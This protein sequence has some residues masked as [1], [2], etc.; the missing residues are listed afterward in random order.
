MFFT[1]NHPK[2]DVRTLDITS[3]IALDG[4]IHDFAKSYDKAAQKKFGR[5]IFN[6][7]VDMDPRES[8][9]RFMES[10]LANWICDALAEDYSVQEGD[11]TVDI[12]IL[13]GFNFA[14]KLLMHTGD[15]TLGDVYGNRRL[16]CE[17]VI[18][19][20]TQVTSSS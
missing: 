10:T 4:T 3:E 20:V 12:A 2:I 16:R 8:C 14:G 11:Q 6:T 1:P 18:Q 19:H 7:A 17:C 15:F 9:V 13:Q 5:V